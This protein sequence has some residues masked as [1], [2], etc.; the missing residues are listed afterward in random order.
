LFVINVGENHVYDCSLF[1]F[2]LN[3]NK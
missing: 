1:I 3:I 2:L